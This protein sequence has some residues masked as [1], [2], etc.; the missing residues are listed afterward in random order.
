MS[1]R[2]RYG[3]ALLAKGWTLCSV[4]RLVSEP[5][6][7]N[8]IHLKQCQQT[9]DGLAQA[10]RRDIQGLAVLGNRTAGHDDTL[11]AE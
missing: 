7:H 1:K 2:L 9:L 10:D 3:V 11:L 4:V 8:A 5:F 6:G